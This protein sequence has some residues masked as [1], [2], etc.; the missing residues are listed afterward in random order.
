[1]EVIDQ[2]RIMHKAGHF[3]GRSVMQ[4]AEPIR[5]WIKATQSRTVLD[6]GSGKGFQYSI[7]GIHHRWGVSVTCYDPAVPGID[8]LPPEEFDGVICSD[9]L[10]HIPKNEVESVIG[11]LFAKA[12]KFVFASVC[13]RPAKKNLPDGRN[14]HL[15]IEP[16]D[17]WKAKFAEKA[18]V[19]YDLVFNE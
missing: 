14:C 16:E 5:D 19:P 13:C 4:W 6:Y 3:V 18:T 7:D 8:V 9:V 17:W 15:T 11:T 12:E 2:Y 1:M 10:E